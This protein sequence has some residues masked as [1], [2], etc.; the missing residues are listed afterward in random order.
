VVT[1]RAWSELASLF[2]PDAAITVDTR[3][4]TPIE[5][6][7]GAELGAFIERAIERFELFVF[8]ILNAVSEVDGDDPDAAW[9]RMYICEMRA[10]QGHESRAYGLYQDRFARTPDGW[11]FAARHYSSLA[12]TGAD[13]AVFPL[14]EAPR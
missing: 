5:L 3:T 4:A 14:L 12:R 11:A 1:R 6:H 7:G 9:G 8:S 13:L 10:E 2:L